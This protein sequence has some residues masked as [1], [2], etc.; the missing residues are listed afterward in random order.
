MNA[1]DRLAANRVLRYFAQHNT[2]QYVLNE[3]AP[4]RSQARPSI[5]TPPRKSGLSIVPVP[6]TPTRQRDVH[7][8][9]HDIL[10]WP[11]CPHFRLWHAYLG[12]YADGAIAEECDTGS[13]RAGTGSVGQADVRIH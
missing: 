6:G 11:T 4:V 10:N 1:V 3:Y 13:A 9:F 12:P 8:V 7:L 2:M 5:G